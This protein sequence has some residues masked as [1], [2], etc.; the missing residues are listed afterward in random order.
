MDAVWIVL[1]LLLLIACFFILPALIEGADYNPEGSGTRW[2]FY[3]SLGSRQAGVADRIGVDKGV[4]Q[5]VVGACQ[6]T[7]DR[8]VAGDVFG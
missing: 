7:R 3:K 1:G 5:I 8:I 2:P 4:G 6:T